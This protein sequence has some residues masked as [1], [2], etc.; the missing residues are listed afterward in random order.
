M[1]EGRIV[2]GWLN[3]NLNKEVIVGKVK[4]VCFVEDGIDPI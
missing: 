3:R 2:C 4:S 1:I